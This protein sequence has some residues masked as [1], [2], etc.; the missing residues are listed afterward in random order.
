MEKI[1]SAQ[2]QWAQYP[3]QRDSTIRYKSLFKGTP[4][5]PD[6]FELSIVAIGE[7]GNYSPRHRHN[8]EQFRYPL[9]GPFNQSP[10][11]DIP[12]GN[13]GYLA[14]GTYYGPFELPAGLEFLI[15][16]CGGPNGCGYMSHDELM[17]GTQALK[18]TGEFT[19][20]VYR[21]F[22]KG[23]IGDRL[24]QDAY[25]AVWEHVN[26]KRISYARARY[27]E[28]ITIDPEAF[29]WVPV[30]AEPGVQC[31]EFGPFNECGTA[32][33]F[34]RIERGATYV[35]R[36]DRGR[37]LAVVLHGEV[38]H[39]GQGWDVHSGFHLQPGESALLAGASTQH[40]TL[41][42]LQLAQQDAS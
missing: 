32:A 10:G 25:E 42:V 5:T 27:R 24:N 18:A 4:Q 37:R 26:G 14:E 7:G 41:L 30:A 9:N 21:R 22:E 15:L 20:G 19:K 40:A 12:K 2:L 3:G 8:F 6:N 16:Q 23:G 17:A 36:A 28:A 38:N 35:L 39:G 1:S 13:L 33:C 29:P 11:Q 34:V 31:R